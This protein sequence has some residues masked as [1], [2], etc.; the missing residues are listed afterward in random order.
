MN[1]A[2]KYFNKQLFSEIM[3]GM[4]LI[5]KKELTEKS[6]CFPIM[7][8]GKG[9]ILKRKRLPCIISKKTVS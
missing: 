4:Q 5:L 2:Q 3:V 8:I 6:L 9:D 7:L 1:I